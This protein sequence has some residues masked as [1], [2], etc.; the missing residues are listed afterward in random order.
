MTPAMVALVQKQ[1]SW[2]R[3][4]VK[5]NGA[6]DAYWQELGLFIAQYDGIIDGYTAAAGTESA[7]TRIQLLA[8]VLQ[9]EIGD[10]A[11]VRL[12]VVFFFVLRVWLIWLCACAGHER[13]QD[14][15][16]VPDDA[17]PAQARHGRA[18]LVAGAP[19]ARQHGAAGEP[20]HVV[21]VQH[22]AAHLQALRG[23]RARRRYSDCFLRF[24]PL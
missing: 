16:R 7:L 8:Y 3:A 5:A 23:T 17:G 20:R 4:N 18:L 24:P 2:M 9:F 12:R 6:A 15:R 13:A 21:R 10:Y 22:H 19:D 1:D 14:A 11:A